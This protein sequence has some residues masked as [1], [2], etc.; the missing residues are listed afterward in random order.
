MSLL[1]SGDD[2]VVGDQN[3]LLAYLFG[4]CLQQ[5]NFVRH[6]F[7]DLFRQLQHLSVGHLHL[8]DLLHQLMQVGGLVLDGLL[9]TSADLVEG[10]V[11]Q[12]LELCCCLWVNVGV[13]VEIEFAG[14]FDN[15]RHRSIFTDDQFLKQ[16]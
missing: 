1:V 13:G 12:V 11:E 9:V 6:Q 5:L 3:E 8:F 15:V 10:F 7:A 2:V 4:F 16:D 14:G